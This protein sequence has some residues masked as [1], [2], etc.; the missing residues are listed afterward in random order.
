MTRKDN[1]NADQSTTRATQ[2][3]WAAAAPF[4]NATQ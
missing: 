2:I 4:F 3:K 1:M